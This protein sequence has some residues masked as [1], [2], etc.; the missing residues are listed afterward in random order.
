MAAREGCMTGPDRQR[1]S[2]PQEHGGV[3]RDWPPI[4]CVLISHAVALVCLLALHTLYPI[5][6][7]IVTLYPIP[8]ALSPNTLIS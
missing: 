3:D 1:R 6:Y 7:P 4:T 8:Y 2:T 5:P